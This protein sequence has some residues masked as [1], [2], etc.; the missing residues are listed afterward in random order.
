[1]ARADL[2]KEPEDVS[3]MFDRVAKRYDL[4]NDLLSLGQTKRWRKKVV[5]MIAPKTGMK[6]LDIAAGTGSSSEPLANGGAEVTALDFS[7]GML[8]TGRRLR[9]KINFIYGDALNLPFEAESF[10]VTTISFGL[11]NTENVERALSEAERVTKSGGAIYVIEFSQPT[12]SLFRK[13]YLKYLIAALPKIAKRFASN[14][15]AYIYLAE[16][17]MAWPNQRELAEIMKR[18]GWK[19]V[20]WRNLTGGVVAVHIG[21]K[22]A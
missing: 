21:R 2:N 22:S 12:F 19:S 11:R 5:A 17:I 10:D 7:K 13:I 20:E 18:S 8:E 9:P 14:P 6:I 16:S 1:V 4:V 3:R 15:E